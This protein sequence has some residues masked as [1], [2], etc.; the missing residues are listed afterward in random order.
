MDIP[1]KSIAVNASSQQPTGQ[2][3]NLHTAAAPPLTGAI[4]PCLMRCGK[5]KA[6]KHLMAVFKR[7]AVRSLSILP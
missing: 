6:A 4:A 7:T 1:T 5:L 3:P 2:K